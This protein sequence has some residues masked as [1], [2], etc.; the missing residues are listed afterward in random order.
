[1]AE[2]AKEARRDVA[3]GLRRIRSVDSPRRSRKR[4][5]ARTSG[6]QR[7][8]ARVGLPAAP[9]DAARRA[10]TR[11]ARTRKPE[12]D[13]GGL[14]AAPDVPR[15]WRAKARMHALAPE[16]AASAAGV[17]HSSSNRPQA[18]DVARRVQEHAVPLPASRGSRAVALGTTTD[19]NF[20]V[21]N[22]D[23]G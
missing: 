11:T 1:V 19:Q 21:S 22:P 12:R 17:D 13:G 8:S 7:P 18:A 2:V 4:A 10:G 15:R 20:R 14:P 6:T 5:D 23:G 3:L 16:F 9:Q